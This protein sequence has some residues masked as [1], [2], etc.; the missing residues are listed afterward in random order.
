M[1]NLTKTSAE[2][3]A[4]GSPDTVEPSVRGDPSAYHGPHDLGTVLDLVNICLLAMDEVSDDCDGKSVKT[5]LW[6]AY[7]RLGEAIAEIE[8]EEQQEARS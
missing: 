1:A 4:A 5:M 6:L 2:L 8:E 3:A 7:Q